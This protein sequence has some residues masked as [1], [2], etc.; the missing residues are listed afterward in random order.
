MK[1]IRV[2][3]FGLFISLLGSLPLG[4]LN[5]L[6]FKIY[7]EQSLTAAIYFSLGVAIVEVAYVRLS[8]IG[9]NWVLRHKRLFE[10]LEYITVLLFIGLAVVTYVATTKQTNENSKTLFAATPPFIRGFL[11]SAINPVQIPFWF[12]WSSYLVS[13]KKLEQNAVQ[14]NWYCSGIGVGTLLGLALYMFGGLWL[15]QQ[16]GANQKQIN[17]FV[18][19]VFLVTALLQLYK[20]L[21]NKSKLK[22]GELDDKIASFNQQNVHDD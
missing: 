6:A 14:Y 13:N 21:T 16:I 19:G 7:V 15:V 22:T 17:Y 18:A 9:M 1:L 11:M 5:V 10:I 12:L 8:L 20:I 4:S 3:G 2:F